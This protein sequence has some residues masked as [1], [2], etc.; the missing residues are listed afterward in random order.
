M[1]MNQPVGFG[2]PLEWTMHFQKSLFLVSILNLAAAGS[3]CGSPMSGNG[4][5]AAPAGATVAKT[6][7]DT[8]AAPIVSGR[9]VSVHHKTKLHH[10]RS[11]PDS[12]SE[13]SL[14]DVAPPPNQ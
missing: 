8:H 14:A 2:A 9:S 10:V 12:S 13:E 7:Y 5:D 6:A 4:S 11:N 3:A 1:P